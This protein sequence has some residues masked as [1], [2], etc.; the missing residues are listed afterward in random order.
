MRQAGRI[1]KPYRDLR[2]DH[3][4]ILKLFT[5]PELAA[6]ITLMPIEMLGVD[7]AMAARELA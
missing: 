1:L 4:S 6:E 5:T 7:A 3:G 2:Q